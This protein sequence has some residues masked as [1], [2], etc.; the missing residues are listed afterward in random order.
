[1]NIDT[2]DHSA[3]GRKA[4]LQFRGMP[5]RGIGLSWATEL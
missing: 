2:M 3:Q 1:M 5:S 4:H